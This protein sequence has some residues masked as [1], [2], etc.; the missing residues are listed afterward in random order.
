[1]PRPS[2]GNTELLQVRVTP[3]QAETLARFAALRNTT[4]AEL[5]R[6]QLRGLV[7]QIQSGNIH[8]QA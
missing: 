4:V 3:Q 2:T 1:M 5:V 7:A 8:P 6:Q